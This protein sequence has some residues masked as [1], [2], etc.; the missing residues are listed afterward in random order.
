MDAAQLSA[1]LR[2]TASPA[3]TRRPVS[4]LKSPSNPKSNSTQAYLAPEHL[5]ES[6]QFVFRRCSTSSVWAWQTSGTYL[7]RAWRLSARP[8]E[9]TW[10]R[11]QPSCSSRRMHWW[12]QTHRSALIDLRL[13]SSRIVGGI[14]W[15]FNNPRRPRKSRVT[16]R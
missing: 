6:S 16:I 11:T 2:F 3:A 13:M 14:L 12:D 1:R 10:K 5:E 7:R 4:H 8:S 15:T 9:C